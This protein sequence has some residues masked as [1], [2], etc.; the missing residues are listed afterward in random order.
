MHQHLWNQQA[1]L[2]S[3]V[4]RQ[5]T[6]GI[7]LL[8]R[9]FDGTGFETWVLIDEMK[10]LQGY[11]DMVTGILDDLSVNM[12]TVSLVTQETLDEIDGLGSEVGDHLTVALMAD[13]ITAIATAA[14]DTPSEAATGQHIADR[15]TDVSLKSSGVIKI[16][17][18]TLKDTV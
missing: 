17:Y 13:A 3:G 9:C 4:S 11:S 16:S 5:I 7:G 6:D 2:P 15:I 12:T 14:A 8:S 10:Y 18:R 1:L